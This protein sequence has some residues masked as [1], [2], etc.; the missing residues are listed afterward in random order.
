[1]ITIKKI[2]LILAITIF[3]YQFAL[4]PSLH[5]HSCF[6][7]TS[8]KCSNTAIM[9][10]DLDQYSLSSSEINLHKE[11]TIPSN[12]DWRNA[13][14][15][16]IQGDWTT[17]AKNQRNRCYAFT[18]LGALES[19][20]KIREKCVNFTPDL[21]EQ[22]LINHYTYY[23]FLKNK[24]GH[25]VFEHCY[26]YKGLSGIDLK[27]QLFNI[28]RLSPDWEKYCI[29]VSN[30]S[31]TVRTSPPLNPEERRNELKSLILE[32]GPIGL[33]IY[34]PNM[35]V[36]TVGSL[37]NWGIFHRGPN[38]Y[39]SGNSPAGVFNQAVVLVGWRDNPMIPN[40]GYWIVKN[41]WSSLWGCN[42]FFNLEYGSLNSDCGYYIWVDY[43]PN[44]FNWPP[45][46]NPVL[47]APSHVKSGVEYQCSFTSVD[48][49]ENQHHYQGK[50]Y[51][52]FS[53]GDYTYSG[54]LGPYESGEK[55]L[56]SHIWSIGGLVDI[57]VKARDD[58]N[59]DG[60]F[61]DGAETYWMS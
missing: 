37:R 23:D 46:G 16:G 8:F 31:V 36:F 2:I 57:K 38:D 52:N 12:W 34:A 3:V 55:C 32:N 27:Y 45:L 48:P 51:Y 30:F 17:P 60:D 41:S 24:S 21:S 35:S 14:H 49:E 6:E 25:A 61:S 22:Y 50:V 1:M 43:D 19:I 5:S 44:S 28:T 58:P 39:Y 9:E 4:S 15:A 13:E 18:I 20:I 40:G 7:N 33:R 59:G 53:F 42:G 29:P 47:V 11:D 26:P 10:N 56:V 54:W